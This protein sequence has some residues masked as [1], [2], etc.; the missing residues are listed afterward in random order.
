V[1][2]LLKTRTCDLD[3][4]SKEAQAAYNSRK[5]KITTKQHVFLT[6]WIKDFDVKRAAIAAGV[7][8]KTAFSTGCQWLDPSR[9]PLSAAMAQRMKD[10]LA[11]TAILEAEEIRRRIHTVL[12]VS[13]LDHFTPDGIGRWLISLEDL[14][15]LPLY[16]QQMID[17]I[18]MANVQIKET[19]KEKNEDGE[20][21]EVETWVDKE[22]ARV[23]FISKSLALELAAKYGLTEK[24]EH[25]VNLKTTNWDD[26]AIKQDRQKPEDPVERRIREAKLIPAEV[27]NGEVNHAEEK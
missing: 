12:N 18:E 26:L 5:G 13:W 4:R 7:S 25:D 19:R 27:K 23:K 20:V 22:I 24:H 1:A 3:L 15:A 6:E 14:K 9:F 21:V 17:G 2:T 11:E 16:I 10:R 8:E